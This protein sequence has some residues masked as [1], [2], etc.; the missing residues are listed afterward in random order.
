MITGGLFLGSCRAG[1]GVSSGQNSD[2]PVIP[3][4]PMVK[5]GE[6]VR[7]VLNATIFKMNGDYADNVAITLNSDGSIAYYPDPSDISES[8]SPVALGNGWY[9]NRQGIGPESKFTSFTFEEYKNLK[10]LPSHQELVE[11]IIPEAAVTEFVEIPVSASEAM[12]NPQICL[13]YLP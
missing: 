13:Q 6:E 7:A 3:T 4:K 10:S 1:K 11:S 12:T 5:G 2:I 8:S 9:L